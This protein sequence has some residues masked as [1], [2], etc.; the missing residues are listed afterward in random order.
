MIGVLGG[1][2]DPIHFGHINPLYEL[3]DI[4]EFNQ[5]R[6]VSNV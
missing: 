2:F 5:I 4:F 6:L 3:S 1:S